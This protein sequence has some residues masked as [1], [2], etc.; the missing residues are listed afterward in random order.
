MALFA[1]LKR[2]RLTPE[3]RAEREVLKDQRTQITYEAIMSDLC[4]LHVEPSTSR[5]SEHSSDQRG[6]T[7]QQIPATHDR[8]VTDLAVGYDNTH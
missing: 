5:P 3:E 7:S 1:W 2:K 6:Q 8:R 4:Y